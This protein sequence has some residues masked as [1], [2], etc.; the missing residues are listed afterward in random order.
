MEKN[1]TDRKNNLGKIHLYAGDGKGKTTAAVGLA[2]RAA[3]NGLNILFMQ[4][5]KAGNSGEINILKQIPNI[6][7]LDTN[8]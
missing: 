5:L 6:K 2:V 4:F 3:G 1:Q 8:P 7:I